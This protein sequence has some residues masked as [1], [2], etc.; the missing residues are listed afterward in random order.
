[1]SDYPLNACFHSLI[2]PTS[3]DQMIKKEAEATAAIVA[4]GPNYEDEV[5]AAYTALKARR[6]NERQMANCTNRKAKDATD[7]VNVS[8]LYL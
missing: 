6:K 5:L 7:L 3:V 8:T 1:V 2:R 4:I